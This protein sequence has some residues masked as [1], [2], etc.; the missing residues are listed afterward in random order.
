MKE[1]IPITTVIML[2]IYNVIV[3]DI[4]LECFNNRINTMINVIYMCASCW[5]L[6]ILK[7]V[8]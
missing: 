2:R 6:N 8:V 4:V 3:I 5:S 1:L 7:F